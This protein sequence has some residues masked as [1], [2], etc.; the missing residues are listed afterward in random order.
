MPMSRPRIQ[1]SRK[2]RPGAAAVWMFLIV[3]FVVPGIAGAVRGLGIPI[4]SSDASWADWILFW[5]GVSIG[6]FAISKAVLYVISRRG[7]GQ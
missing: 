3:G 5:F 2:I 6:T 4:R 1:G 7:I